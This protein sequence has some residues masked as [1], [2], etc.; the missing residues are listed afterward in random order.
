MREQSNLTFKS[1]LEYSE[2]DDFTHVRAPRDSLD[3]PR[4]WGF[5]QLNKEKGILSLNIVNGLI[6]TSREAPA[7]DG[8][9]EPMLKMVRKILKS[10]GIIVFAGYG[11]RVESSRERVDF[12]FHG[13]SL[14][15]TNRPS[16]EEAFLASVN[17]S[18]NGACAP[19]TVGSRDVT[20]TIGPGETA[21]PPGGV[22]TRKVEREKFLNWLTVTLDITNLFQPTSVVN[23]EHGDLH[24][25]TTS[26]NKVYADGIL[27]STAIAGPF[28]YGYHFYFRSDEERAGVVSEGLELIPNEKETQL[29]CRIWEAAIDKDEVVLPLFVG[30]LRCNPEAVDVAGITGFLQTGTARKIWEVLVSEVGREKVFCREMVLFFS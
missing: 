6:L 26:A 10:A 4:P 28:Q 22:F 2:T 20:I 15:F 17:Q 7:A 23:T 16:T 25:D 19:E 13:E 30:L 11:A 3:D 24:L 9:S 18:S 29:R 8:E 21:N 5:I 1:K 27:L 14:A 12:F